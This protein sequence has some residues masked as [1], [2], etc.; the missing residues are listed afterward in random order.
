MMIS[1]ALPE[2]LGNS[3]AHELSCCFWDCLCSH[4]TAAEHQNILPTAG[5]T[6]GLEVGERRWAA[7]L[8]C[9]WAVS[10]SWSSVVG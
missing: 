5:I 7:I 3:V 2:C 10:Y 6:W 8:P 9:L 1:L 4:W